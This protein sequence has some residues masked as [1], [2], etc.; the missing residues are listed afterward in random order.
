MQKAKKTMKQTV[1]SKLD[2]CYAV[3]QSSNSS[4]ADKSE[5]LR[6]LEMLSKKHKVD[7]QDFIAA[8]DF[9][10]EVK[11][12]AAAKAAAAKAA[13]AEVEAKAYVAVNKRISRRAAIISML[14]DNMFDVDSINEV[15][16]TVYNYTDAKANK[17]AIAGTRYDLTVNKNMFFKTCADSRIFT[18]K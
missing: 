12:R 3:V 1:E 4:F 2:K 16:Q 13:A 8:K 5:A 10:V 6:Q 11:R 9:D 18:V 14:F 17:K 15:L 7:L